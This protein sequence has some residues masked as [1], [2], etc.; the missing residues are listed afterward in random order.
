M[1]EGAEEPGNEPEPPPKTT[2][3]WIRRTWAWSATAE[4]QRNR[5]VGVRSGQNES[6]EAMAEEQQRKSWN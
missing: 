6:A 5:G 1:L 3:W 2:A 4:L